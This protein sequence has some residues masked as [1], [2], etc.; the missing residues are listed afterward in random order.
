MFRFL[1]VFVNVF[2][3]IQ[4]VFLP[5][6]AKEN[7]GCSSVCWNKKPLYPMRALPCALDILASVC[8]DFSGSTSFSF[9]RL[10]LFLPSSVTDI[11]SGDRTLWV[12]E[13]G[14]RVAADCNVIFL[15]R[16]WFVNLECWW[17][18]FLSLSLSLSRQCQLYIYIY[19]Y[20]YTHIYIYICIHFIYIYIY[21][22]IYMYIY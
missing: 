2:A 11:L 19:I 21:M 22:Y 6:R 14:L 13:H 5:A 16:R 9:F 18:F 15:Y 1:D 12:V 8:E 4:N 20:I 17:C 3:C 10:V 7:S